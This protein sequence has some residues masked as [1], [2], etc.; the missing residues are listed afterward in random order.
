M[1]RFLSSKNASLYHQGIKAMRLTWTQAWRRLNKK[2]KADAVSRRRNRRRVRLQKAVGGISLDELRKK[3]AQKPAFRKAQRE[4]AARQVKERRQKAAEKK[5]KKPATKHQRIP[6]ASK[7][8]FS[9]KG[10]R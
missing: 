8:Q 4:A 9:K 2:V 3:C 1:L 6:G 10:R 7:A 5:S